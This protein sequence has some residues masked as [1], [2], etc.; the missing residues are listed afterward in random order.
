LVLLV[1][2]GV[3][4][5]GC[6]LLFQSISG[7]REEVVTTEQ[8]TRRVQISTDPPGAQVIRVG[9]DGIPT[10]IGAAPLEASYS[11]PV[12]IESQEPRMGWMVVGLAVDLAF[13][14]GWGA[15]CLLEE[16]R[17]CR[18]ELKAGTPVVVMSLLGDGIFGLLAYRRKPIVSERPS[19]T[20][21]VVFYGQGDGFRSVMVA[22]IGGVERLD[23]ALTEP[24]APSRLAGG[25][26]I[27]LELHHQLAPTAQVGLLLTAIEDGVTSALSGLGRPFATG[28]AQPG[29]ETLH[30]EIQQEGGLCRLR[31]WRVV[32]E[33][34]AAQTMEAATR[35]PCDPDLQAAEAR[36]LVVGL[37]RPL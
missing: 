22:P 23:L 18:N 11:E 27:R 21:S 26:A 24:Y 12:E 34:A 31:L 30:L 17:Y 3:G 33:G 25:P 10:A 8:R 29:E 1:G 13:T 2:V 28:L 7:W 32:A 35:S 20:P 5:G 4:N 9:A 14:L 36:S 15:F 37:L 6:G 16:Q 19:T